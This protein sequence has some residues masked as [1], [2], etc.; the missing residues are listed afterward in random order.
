MGRTISI[1]FGKDGK[2]SK[3]TGKPGSKQESESLDFG[4]A[5][6]AAYPTSGSTTPTKTSGEAPRLGRFGA[7]DGVDA[8]AE[9]IQAQSC[10]QDVNP[11]EQRDHPAD[12]G[13]ISPAATAKRAKRRPPTEEEKSYTSLPRK[14]KNESHEDWALR[15]GEKPEKLPSRPAHSKPLGTPRYDQQMD[16]RTWLRANGYQDL[17]ER[18]DRLLAEWKEAKKRTRRDWWLVLAGSPSGKPSMT[19]G[20]PWPMLTAFRKRQGYPVHSDSIERGPHELAP[21]VFA[22]KR[23]GS[24][25]KRATK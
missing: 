13:I 7:P 6:M 15:V 21:S 10:R 8:D 16:A 22:Q 1:R 5:F 12:A 11:A 18:I 23:W 19:G 24:H 17:A 14:R 25:F 20:K 2:V 4:N 3:V 9:R